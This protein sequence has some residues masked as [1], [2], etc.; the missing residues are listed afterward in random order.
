MAKGKNS[1]DFS[2]MFASVPPKEQTPPE[3]PEQT[4]A[5]VA[6]TIIQE[7]TEDTVAPLTKN[8]S[9]SAAKRNGRKG[10]GKTPRSGGT[11]VKT[12]SFSAEVW[13]DYRYLMNILN[14]SASGD[15]EEYMRSEIKKNASLLAAVKNLRK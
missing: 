15:I 7:H 5:D 13:E 10:E 8:G 11:A 2:S 6:E 3:T 1:F 9:K 12:F 14:K 4:A